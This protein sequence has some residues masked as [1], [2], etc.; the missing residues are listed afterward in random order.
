MKKKVSTPKRK[1]RR[2]IYHPYK[3][4]TEWLKAIAVEDGVSLAMKVSKEN[5]GVPVFLRIEL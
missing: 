3:N 1:K 4:K 2:S 5:P